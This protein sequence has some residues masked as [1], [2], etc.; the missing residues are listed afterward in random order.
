MHPPPDCSI[1]GE[2][3][4][5]AAEVGEDDTYAW[6]HVQYQSPKAINTAP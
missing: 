1:V 3:E 4:L 5:V 6:R 2:M